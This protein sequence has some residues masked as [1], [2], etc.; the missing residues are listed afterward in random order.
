MRTL[1]LLL[2][3]LLIN[4]SSIAQ[5]PLDLC[6]KSVNSYCKKAYTL[7]KPAEWKNFRKEPYEFPDY[8]IDIYFYKL[9]GQQI[10]KIDNSTINTLNRFIDKNNVRLKE[11]DELIGYV[12]TII[13]RK[14]KSNLYCVI[15][16]KE[17]GVTFDTIY[18]C[19]KPAN[20]K[21]VIL[22]YNLN[23]D[24]KLYSFD[25]NRGTYLK[26]VYRIQHTYEALTKGG[27]KK[28][29]TSIFYLDTK[30]YEVIS[31]EDI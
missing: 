2:L 28:Y 10:E 30:T 7:Y 23:N 15:P 26:P 3:L 29:F 9:L 5:T 21:G 12:D 16:I 25:P 1:R 31:E 17:N 20:S 4:N 22:N 24:I 27:F 19:N 8:S 11:D 13:I 14:I 18:F 6:K